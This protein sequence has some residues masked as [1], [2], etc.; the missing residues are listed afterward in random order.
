MIVVCSGEAFNTRSNI[1]GIKI[2]FRWGVILLFIKCNLQIKKHGVNVYFVEYKMPWQKVDLQ[3]FQRV[4]AY[5]IFSPL[6]L[7]LARL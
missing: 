5:F 4:E 7:L 3:C 6:V 1:W 2:M